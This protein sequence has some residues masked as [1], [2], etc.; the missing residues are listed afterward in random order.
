MLLD[1][2]LVFHVVGSCVPASRCAR[3]DG[4]RGSVSIVAAE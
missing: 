1:F 4:R 2:S 3:Y